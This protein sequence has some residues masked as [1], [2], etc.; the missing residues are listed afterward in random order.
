MRSLSTLR[1]LQVLLDTTRECMAQAVVAQRRAARY[2]DRYKNQAEEFKTQAGCSRSPDMR[3]RLLRIAASL[4]NLGRLAEGI[5]RLPQ[6][7]FDAASAPEASLD[8]DEAPRI[9]EHTESPVSNSSTESALAQARRHVAQAEDQVARQRAL[10]EKLSKNDKHIALIAEAKGLLYTL[11]HTLIL[12]RRH[13][14]LELS[15]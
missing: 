2:A 1:E 4:E 14:S 6:P 8:N 5:T 3:A 9:T 13:L 7:P 15:K 12:A 11:E 10:V